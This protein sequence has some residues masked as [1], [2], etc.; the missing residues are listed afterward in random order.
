MEPST[1]AP[2]SVVA[3]G[4]AVSREMRDIGASGIHEA[5]AGFALCNA[6][7]AF[8]ESRLYGELSAAPGG[9]TLDVPQAVARHGYDH[10]QAVGLLR[11][12]VTQD[13]FK[14]EP[15]ERFRLTPLGEATLAD[16]ALGFL[17]LYRGGYGTLMMEGLRLLDGRAVYGRDLTR[18]G[19]YVA[20]GA[21]EATRAVYNAVPLSVLERSGVRTIVDLG[22]GAASFLIEFVR[23]SPDHRGIGVDVDARALKAAREQ[24]RSAGLDD[25]IR[26]VQGDAFDL[27][28]IAEECRD[29]ERF[30]SF[31]MEHELLRDGQDAVLRHIDRMAELFPGKGYLLGEPMLQM[32]REDGAFYW[33]HVL[34]SQGIPRNIAGWS[35]LLRGLSRARLDQVFIPDYERYCAFF[36]LR[37]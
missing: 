34:S 18:D 29:G 27:A 13:L 12:L 23:R 37:F 2:I 31:A 19:H 24:V 14:E 25:R 21:S 10:R 26:L 35:T 8:V 36:D 6:L 20:L 4:D 28:S 5:I 30:Y 1:S 22:C 3:T 32:S 9:R 16:G 11:Y 33:F 17:H 15:H 7:F